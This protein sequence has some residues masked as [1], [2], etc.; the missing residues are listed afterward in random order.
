MAMLFEESPLTLSKVEFREA[1]SKDY[2]MVP[3]SQTSLI[4]EF[5]LLNSRAKILTFSIVRISYASIEIGQ[6]C[7]G[8]MTS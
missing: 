7:T 1:N 2:E 6:T 8:L 3:S 5:S 4:W